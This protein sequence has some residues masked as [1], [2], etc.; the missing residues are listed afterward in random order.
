MVAHM[1]MRQA[2]RHCLRDGG[3][4]GNKDIAP[5][6]YLIWVVDR[7][8]EQFPSD[9][10]HVFVDEELDLSCE[11]AKQP[12]GIDGAPEEPKRSQLGHCPG[13]GKDVVEPLH[14][15]ISKGGAALAC[16]V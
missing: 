10:V 7:T 2:S 5:G 4:K 8:S 14:C 13:E 15:G 11:M 9:A 12:C 6:R 16:R 3:F 1:R